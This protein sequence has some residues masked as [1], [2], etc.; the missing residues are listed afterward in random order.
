MLDLD[1]DNELPPEAF[2]WRFAPREA[3]QRGL[4]DT[5]RTRKKRR[6]ALLLADADLYNELLANYGRHVLDRLIEEGITARA[7]LC[8]VM[9]IEEDLDLWLEATG[10]RLVFRNLGPAERRGLECWLWERHDRQRQEWRYKPD[11]RLNHRPDQEFIAHPSKQLWHGL[12]NFAGLVGDRYRNVWPGIAAICELR[13]RQS[14][15][16]RTTRDARVRN[17]RFK[18][19]KT[20]LALTAW[21]ASGVRALSPACYAIPRLRAPWQWGR[22][23]AD[24]RTA[25]SLSSISKRSVREHKAREHLR[26]V[27]FGYHYLARENGLRWAAVVPDKCASAWA[28]RYVEAPGKALSAACRRLAPLRRLWRERLPDD[29]DLDRLATSAAIEAGL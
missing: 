7:F 29:D 25:P 4:T 6:L 28:L 18:D 10:E 9:L 13:K 21:P 2:D 16:Q 26:A 27:F 11:R 20:R 17:L 15:A 5:E 23:L 19:G 14:R 22:P 3:R 1:E 12:H 8:A 24:T